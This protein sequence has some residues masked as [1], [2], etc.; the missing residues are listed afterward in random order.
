MKTTTIG[1]S[2]KVFLNE[3]GAWKPLPR[4]HV[5]DWDRPASSPIPASTSLNPL[6]RLID[7][8]VL[9]PEAT[10]SDILT[11]CAEARIHHFFSVCVPPCYVA[12]ARRALEGSEVKVCTVIGFPLGSSTSETKRQ[13]TENALKNGADEIDM[14]INIG[15]LKSGQHQKVD[16]DI[17]AVRAACSGKILKTILETCLLSDPEKVAACTIAVAAGADFVKTSTG[18]SK[19]GATIDDIA[20]MRKVVGSRIGVKASGGIRDTAFAKALVSAGATRLGTSA[21]IDIVLD[22]K[23]TLKDAPKDTGRTQFLPY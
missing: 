19:S 20:L 14:V 3:P 23:D 1:T 7:H 12:S 18:F 15:F 6:A 4:I 22:R 16:A 2:G 9:K 13:E 5:A 10:E 8:T 17:R 11:A 21:S